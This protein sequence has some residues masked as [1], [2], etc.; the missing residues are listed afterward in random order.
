MNHSAARF[1]PQA[2]LR[3]KAWLLGGMMLVSMAAMGA[4]QAPAD[5]GAQAATEAYNH[6]S[7]KDYKAAIQEFQEAL[8]ANPSSARWRADL[9]YTDVAAGLL[10]DAAREFDIVY[11]EHPNQLEIALEL[12]YLSQQLHQEAAAEKYFQAAAFS[13]DTKISKPARLALDN[14]RASRLQAWKQ[15]AY[16]L[17][18]RGHRDEA[19]SQFEQLHAADPSDA[20]TTMQLGYLYQASGDLDKARQMFQAENDN[21]DSQVAAQAAS[22]LTEINHESAWW[23]GSV[24]TSPFYQSRFSNQ[25][26]PFDVKVGLRP[27]PYLEPYVGLRFTRDIRSTSGTLPEIYND[28]AAIFSFGLQSAILGHGTNL[29][30]EAGTAISLLGQPTQGRA[31]PD[32]RAGFTWYQPWGTSLADVAKTNPHGVSMTGN[33]YGDVSFYSRYNDNVIGYLQ[34]RQGLNLPTARVLPMQLLAAINVVRDSNG[35]FY[36]NVLEA[37]PALRFAPFRYARDLQV[38]AEY[39]R[40]F[41][42][43]HDSTNPYGPRYGDFRLFLIWSKNF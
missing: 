36:N 39:L 4:G 12:G 25:I 16:D 9:G 40:G 15:R 22:A 14:V 8:A 10:Q 11:R 30:A 42:T 43:V 32:Y 29:Y 21:Q 1:K 41:Y 2:L 7:V 20:A 31:V 24:Y 23:F 34:V 13:P 26:N 19:I 37:G 3:Y 5:P 28:N 38:E 18:A 33:A 35:N 17:L 6:V 27:S